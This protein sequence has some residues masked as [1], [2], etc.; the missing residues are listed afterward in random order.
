MSSQTLYRLSGLSLTLGG[1]II[2]IGQFFQPQGEGLASLQ[3]PRTIPIALIGFVVVILTLLGLPGL[4]A[5]QA[6]RA[7]MLGLVGML[8]LFFSL[9]LL[10]G[11]HSVLNF[12]VR[13][14]LAASPAT[15]RVL[16]AV[17]KAVQSGPLG[18]LISI[19][20][21]MSV[22]GFILLGLATLRAKVLPLWTGV[23]LIVA[24]P[25]PLI[26][27][28]LPLPTFLETL[29]FSVGYLALACPSLFL[30]TSKGLSIRKTE[31][32]SAP[33]VL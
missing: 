1:L 22:F 18:V 33:Q 5:R 28:F 15:A 4:Y 29:G 16:G 32:A 30:L 31:P 13:P 10:D 12:A 8:L 14:E 24:G 6:E 25:I 11:T 9:P 21:L 20:G 17:D 23:A 3:D 2:L 7:G 26:S 19:C 27:L